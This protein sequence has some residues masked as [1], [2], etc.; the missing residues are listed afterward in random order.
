[1]GPGRVCEAIKQQGMKPWVAENDLDPRPRR[2]IARHD[3]S[4]VIPEVLEEHCA[5]YVCSVP[6]PRRSIAPGDACRRHRSLDRPA[7]EAYILSDQN[8]QVCGGSL[9]M[10]RA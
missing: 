9:S 3:A 7:L 5:H 10:H 2:G 4:D 8:G 6:V 1:M